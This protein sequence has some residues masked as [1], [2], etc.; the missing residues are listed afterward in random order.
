M[1]E[2]NPAIVN[3]NQ[4]AS[5]SK[6]LTTPKKR[7]R[8]GTNVVDAF[9]AVP[10]EAVPIDEFRLKHNVSFAVLRQAKRFDKSGLTGTVRVKKDKK[11]GSL[12][13][14]RDVAPSS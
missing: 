1:S 13:I 7:G 6:P 12:M 2:Y 9:S 14:W 4:P 8:Q 10:I 11:T 5:A 3:A